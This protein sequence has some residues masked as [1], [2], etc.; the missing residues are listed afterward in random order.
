MNECAATLRINPFNLEMRRLLV[1]CHVKNGDGQRASAEFKTLMA[2]K[3]PNPDELRRWFDE[4]RIEP[5]KP[6]R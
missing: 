6:I 2:M 3:P 4:L 1:F 5:S